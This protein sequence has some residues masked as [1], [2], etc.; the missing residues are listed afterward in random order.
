MINKLQSH[1]TVA[2]DDCQLLL[3]LF[4]EVSALLS[5]FDPFLL[6][7]PCSEISVLAV[8]LRVRPVPLG[9]HH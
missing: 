3:Q 1:C 2:V 4:Q 5:L 6:Q 7:L 8:Q 9:L